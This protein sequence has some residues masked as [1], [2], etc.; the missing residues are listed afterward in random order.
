MLCTH[1]IET[2]F[3]PMHP[4][5]IQALHLSSI[6]GKV[7]HGRGLMHSRCFSLGTQNPIFL[8]VIVPVRTCTSA[9]TI[10]PSS[11][12]WPVLVTMAVSGNTPD[13]RRVGGT[14][15]SRRTLGLAIY[16]DVHGTLLILP[17][18]V[19]SCAAH[20]LRMPWDPPV[21]NVRLW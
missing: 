19:V 10:S 8:A 1:I 11:R 12:R 17:L 18:G 6:A 5:G 16:N 2:S 21:E 14:L 15:G 20:G 9:C 7:S 13:S 4:Y 3:N